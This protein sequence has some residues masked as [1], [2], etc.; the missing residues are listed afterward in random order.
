MAIWK[1]ADNDPADGGSYYQIQETEAVTNIQ[2][3][4]AEY[5]PANLK[6][7]IFLIPSRSVLERIPPMEYGRTMQRCRCSDGEDV[8]VGIGVDLI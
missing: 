7:G 8:P 4:A 2:I 5:V 1:G 6:F 3:R